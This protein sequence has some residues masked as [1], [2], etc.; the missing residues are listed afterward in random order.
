MSEEAV[1]AAIEAAHRALHTYVRPPDRE[2]PP[3]FDFEAY[4]H[5]RQEWSAQTF[6]PGPR[7][8]SM[9]AHIRKELIE[10]E[11]DPSDVVEWIDVV[12]LALDGAWRS[13]HSPAEIIAALV[14]KQ[15]RNER[16]EWPDWRS[17]SEDQL[18]EHSAEATEVPTQ[19]G[20]GN[21]RVPSAGEGGGSCRVELPDETAARLPLIGRDRVL[22]DKLSRTFHQEARRQGDY[23]PLW[24][25]PRGN[26]FEVRLPSGHVARVTIMLDRLEGD[27]RG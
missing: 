23:T 1:D 25:D 14:A 11:A 17:V 6:G 19:P 4:L 18:I 27:G 24:E 8:K 10:V 22:I 3:R 16:R 20:A 21:L 7:S 15:D 5:R 2:T 13:G 26:H 12:L 9:V